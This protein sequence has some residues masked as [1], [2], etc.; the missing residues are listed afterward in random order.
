MKNKWI[1]GACAILLFSQACTVQKKSV[2]NISEIEVARVIKTLSAD[3]M[4]GRNSL[5]P[6]EI[7]KAADFIASEF[8]AAGLQRFEKQD[9]YR[10]NFIINSI[11][12]LSG[13]LFINGGEVNVEN[14]VV[15][16]TKENIELTTFPNIIKISKG[17]DFFAKYMVLI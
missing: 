2:P 8:K 9:N 3:D 13:K 1:L 16:S 5:E 14:Y 17:D 10:Q 4:L 15:S 7:S 12:P 11:K 6:E